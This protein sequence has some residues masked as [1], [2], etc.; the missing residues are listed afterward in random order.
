MGMRFR[1]LRE[2]TSSVQLLSNGRDISGNDWTQLPNKCKDS[3]N[4]E[5]TL[6]VHCLYQMSPL[7]QKRTTSTLAPPI[8]YL[9][10]H[11]A[12]NT[13]KFPRYLIH[14]TKEIQRKIQKF[15]AN[16]CPCS[17][18]VIRGYE[19]LLPT[20]QQKH[21]EVTQVQTKKFFL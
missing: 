3:C 8:S 5:P 13:W 18:D 20:N 7:N 1:I 14:F 4:W 6:L 11:L 21:I 16:Y 17:I 12:I 10:K 15:L 19:I 9:M 2:R